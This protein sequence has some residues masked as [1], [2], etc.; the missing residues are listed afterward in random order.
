MVNYSPDMP[1]RIQERVTETGL[2]LLVVMLGL[3]GLGLGRHT[4]SVLI[5][6]GSSLGYLLMLLLIIVVYAA[7]GV[8]LPYAYLASRGFDSGFII[9]WPD[10]AAALW[11][12]GLVALAPVLLGVGTLIR[13]V[14]ISPGMELEWVV[15]AVLVVGSVPTAPGLPEPVDLFLTFIVLQGGFGLVVGTLFHGVF[16]NS[17]RR[18]TSTGLAVGATALAVGLLLEGGSTNP[19]S[20]VVGV[21]FAAAVSYAYDRT[22]NLTVPIVAY[23]VLATFALLGALFLVQVMAG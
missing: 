1:A 17:L 21:L 20:F 10:R 11:L 8:G 6:A 23:V 7:V 12:A 9:E 3:V 4:V 19:A 14:T 16:Q 22:D 13:R 15:P 5:D 2:G 18:I